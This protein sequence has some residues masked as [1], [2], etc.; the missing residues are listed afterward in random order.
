MLMLL[1]FYVS[2]NYNFLLQVKLKK[3]Q[4]KREPKVFVITAEK[5]TGNM[6]RR[7]QRMPLRNHGEAKVVRA[8]VQL[9]CVLLFM[10]S[11]SVTMFSLDQVNILSSTRPRTIKL[12]A[13]TRWSVKI[14]SHHITEL[15]N[16]YSSMAMSNNEFF[17]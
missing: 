5:Y 7:V 4:K 11:L 14:R 2:H 9:T 3:K 17:G 1:N 6:L 8:S 13:S 12:Y 16:L 10:R 15:L